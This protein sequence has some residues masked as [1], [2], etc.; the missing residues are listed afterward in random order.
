MVVKNF[1]FQLKEKEQ[2]IKVK[3]CKTLYSKF[4]GLMFKRNSLPLL[5]IFKK[6]VKISIHSFFCR[7]FIA[8]WFLQNKIIE[9][10][11]IKSNKPS[12]K[13]KKKFDKLLEVPSNSKEYFNLLLFY[14]RCRKI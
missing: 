10:R 5:F 2:K 11:S 8:I 12:I 14:R 1:N 7:P 4:R 13:P 6:P 3:E 9:I